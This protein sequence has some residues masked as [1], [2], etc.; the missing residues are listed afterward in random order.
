[1]RGMHLHETLSTSHDTTTNNIT[2]SPG[3]NPFF[4]FRMCQAVQLC[5]AVCCCRGVPLWTK[6]GRS[7]HDEWW[8]THLLY[9]SIGLWSSCRLQTYGSEKREFTILSP[10]IG[11]RFSQ[12]KIL[13]QLLLVYG[14][15]ISFI[16]CFL[17]ICFIMYL[18]IWV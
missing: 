3:V 7:H 5:R 10:T 17:Y 4:A 15:D 12:V 11:Q 9:G 6:A 18:L 1:M 2:P 13:F 16:K 14:L 8:E